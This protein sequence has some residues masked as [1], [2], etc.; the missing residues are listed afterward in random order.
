MKEVHRYRCNEFV[1][2]DSHIRFRSRG[3]LLVVAAI[4]PLASHS[5][6]MVRL[7]HAVLFSNAH[8]L[9][10]A[11]KGIIPEYMKRNTGQGKGD[12]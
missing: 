1:R 2:R 9:Y 3:E 4:L 10:P 5:F 12:K 6:M 11:K 8:T 7:R